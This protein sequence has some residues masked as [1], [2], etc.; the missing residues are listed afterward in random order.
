MEK[1]KEAHRGTR[2]GQNLRCQKVRNRKGEGGIDEVDLDEGG[3]T[4]K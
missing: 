3:G 4:K 1:G 2:P